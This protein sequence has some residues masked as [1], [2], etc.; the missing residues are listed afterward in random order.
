MEGAVMADIF[1]QIHAQQQTQGAGDIFD[2][3]HVQND[4][5]ANSINPRTGTGYGLYQMRDQNGKTVGIPY[6][7]VPA[8]AQQGFSFAD[9]QSKFQYAKDSAADPNHS[10]GAPL[11]VGS[12]GM[13]PQQSLARAQQIEDSAS[14]PMQVVGGIAKGAGTLARPALDAMDYS[15]TGNTQGVGPMLDARTP[16]QRIA[17]YGTI[18][19]AAAPAAIAAPVATAGGVIGGTLG[20]GAGQVIGKATGMSPGATDLLSD[21]LGVAGGA[22]GAV[23]ARP[24]V[25]ALDFNA[26]K[27]A[28]GALLQSVAHDANQVPVQLDNA[29]DAALRLMDWQKK[30]NLG[31]TVNK[32]LNR[33]TNPNQGPLTYEDARDFYQLFGK[34]SVEEGNKLAPPVKRDLVEMVAGLKQDIGDAA[35]TVGRAADYY[36]GLKDYKTASNLQSWY[37]YAKDTL[38][39]PLVKGAAG[40]AG[41]GG[42]YGLWKWLTGK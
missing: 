35:D 14:L 41:A 20:A 32:F 18:V 3:I 10:G 30:T 22:G 31:P 36:K 25:S 28:A 8:A 16:M 34:M 17:K 15:A 4:V 37:D 7:H 5:T 29:Q 24:L 13:T 23:G 2:Q 26:Q 6:N 12:T 21:A 1:D 27:Q 40:A 9:D 42:V 11:V 19:A 33:I 38:P 39:G